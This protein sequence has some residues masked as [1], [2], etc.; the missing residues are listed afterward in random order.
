M[1]VSGALY[2][3]TKYGGGANIS[4]GVVLKLSPPQ[5]QIQWS[6]TVLHSFAGAPGDG[7]FPSP[8]LTPG[9]NGHL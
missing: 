8:G 2:G 9:A 6:E 7:R 1:H 5:S 4:G 3:T